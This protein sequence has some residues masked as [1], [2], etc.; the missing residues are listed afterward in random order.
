MGKDNCPYPKAGE[1]NSALQSCIPLSLL[2]T[3]RVQTLAISSLNVPSKMREI[4]CFFFVYTTPKVRSLLNIHT[5]VL[6]REVSKY[7]E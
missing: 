7:H 1:I 6:L 4:K 2:A 5:V 3:G